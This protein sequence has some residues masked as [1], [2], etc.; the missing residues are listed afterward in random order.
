MGRTR[1]WHENRV[2]REGRIS[3]CKENKINVVKEVIDE[4]NLGNLVAYDH[5]E[6][7]MR[8]MI[9]IGLSLRFLRNTW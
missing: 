6:V 4:T 1:R 5:S 3:M 2:L 8:I 7:I 9:S